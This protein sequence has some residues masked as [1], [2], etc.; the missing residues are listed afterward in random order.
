MQP[1]ASTS[2]SRIPT[3]HCCEEYVQLDRIE[4]GRASSSRSVSL[5]LR[6]WSDMPS[7]GRRRSGHR[8]CFGPLR[9]RSEWNDFAGGWGDTLAH[10]P[11]LYIAAVD[12]LQEEIDRLNTLA[13][14]A[15]WTLI[16]VYATYSFEQLRA[17]IHAVS[18]DPPAGGVMGSVGV[19]PQHNA[20]RVSLRRVDPD[21]IAHVTSVVPSS[22]V[23]IEIDPLFLK[24]TS[25]P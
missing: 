3:R 13:R 6:R 25:L 10:Q 8:P 2:P 16:F 12:P 1:L 9:R 20:I 23:R 7:T 5:R 4:R 15:T 11:T 18:K 14:E 22:A 17:F 21:A 19:D 24:T